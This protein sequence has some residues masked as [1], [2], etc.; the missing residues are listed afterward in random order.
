M[1]L[2]Q[3]EEDD[4]DE[5]SL[6]RTPRPSDSQY[7]SLSSRGSCLSSGP[8]GYAPGH[9]E[10]VFQRAY[11]SSG[12]LSAPGL[13]PDP[14][15]LPSSRDASRDASFAPDHHTVQMFP[16]AS[17][18]SGLH[19]HSGLGEEQQEPFFHRPEMSARYGALSRSRT[20]VAADGTLESVEELT[21][22]V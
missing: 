1:D 10:H 21:S 2:Q 5:D 19:R 22:T 17:T 7:S 12:L 20:Q 14:C 15:A 6:A 9:P 16:G 13:E 4:D 11:S 3:R 8:P 18:S